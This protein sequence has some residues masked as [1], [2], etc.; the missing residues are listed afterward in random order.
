MK[1]HPNIFIVNNEY[2]FI[3]ITKKPS[4]VVLKI[5]K[6][7]YYGNN[8]GILPVLSPVHRFIVPQKT[9]DKH[10][11]YEVSVRKVIEKRAY[12][13]IYAEPVRKV[14]P[15]K[16][17]RLDGLKGFYFADT[18]NRYDK[19]KEQ[20]KNLTDLDFIIFNG[21]F[22]ETDTI[23][24]IYKLNEFFSDITKGQIPVL[25]ARGNH[26][27]RG[28]YAEELYKYV[29]MNGTN[30]YF[31]FSF[32]S[33]EGLV[34][35][36]GEDKLDDHPEYN[37]SNYFERYRKEELAYIK[38]AKFGKGKY[39]FAF[40]HTSFMLKE[41]MHGPFDINRETYLKWAKALN[42]KNFDCMFCGHIHRYLISPP[43]NDDI[44]PHNYPVI[45]CS[46][47]TKNYENVYGSLLTFKDG[48]ITVNFE[49]DNGDVPD[50]Y[51]I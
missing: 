30:G 25:F 45:T 27:T 1:F 9:L 51:Q 49:K 4:Q 12:F 23:K 38:K 14:Y 21:D 41:S 2:H 33:L 8:G 6:N 34:L 22:G 5:G 35:D 37:N 50:S 43:S 10:G 26:D 11:R 18:H 29:G 19:A 13:P 20:I 46:K 44:Q 48:K 40:C 3:I 36:C 7:T 15:F 32:R 39:R 28:Y 42:E 24:D 47:V 31:K 16:N 17:D